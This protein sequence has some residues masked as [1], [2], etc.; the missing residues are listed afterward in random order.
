M[1][2]EDWNSIDNSI[3]EF[4]NVYCAFIDILGY[5]NKS[6]D[7]FQNEYNLFG[8]YERAIQRVQSIKKISEIFMD[9]SKMEVSFFSDSIII[10]S[11]QIEGS[12]GNILQY[13]RALSANL[14]LEGLFIRGGIS[15]GRHLKAITKTGSTFLA[16]EALQKAYQLE[17]EL[18]INPRVLIE[19]SIVEKANHV[20]KQ[21][22][23]KENSD[24]IVDFASIIIIKNGE[25]E[26]D[27]FN[28]MID[29]QNYMKVGETD[30]IKSKYEWILDYYYWIISISKNFNIDRFT[31]F[32]SVKER[33]FKKLEVL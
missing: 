6:H 18:A 15:E 8:R 5:K 10:T 12:I 9:F 30:S 14:S 20:E 19:P 26:G 32:K 2:H 1:A 23:I 29:I 31:K 24:F 3:N 25:N 33:G 11:P 27:V 13:V 7:F 16:S 28:E 22:I 17:S 4:E 21:L